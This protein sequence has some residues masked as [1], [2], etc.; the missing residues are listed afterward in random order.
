[1][2]KIAAKK[3][4]KANDKYVGVFPFQFDEGADEEAGDAAI[5]TSI[6]LIPIGQWEHDLYGPIIIT[7]NDILEFKANFDAKIRKGVPITAGHE[8]A[9]ELPAV[10]WI[11][12]VEARG[13]GLWGQVEWNE[14]G[15]DALEDKQFKF[16]SPEFYPIYEDAQTHTLYKN[17]LTGGALTKAPYFKELEAIVF[18]EKKLKNKFNHQTMTIA[19]LLA[20]KM[21]DLSTEEKAF[22]KEHAS[23]L[24][25]EQ[26][27]AYTSVIE[28]PTGTEETAEEKTA[29]EAK[30]KEV[31]EKKAADDKAAED[32]KAKGDA[33][34]AAGL[35]RDGSVKIDAS[36]KVHISAGE[37]AL[38][39]K[40]ADEG[41]QAFA[42]LKLQKLTA[43]VSALIFS[44]TNKAGKFL[45]KSKDTLHA[46][47][48]TLSDA[49]KASFNLLLAELPKTQIFSEIGTGAA[50]VEGT[51]QAE[52]EA[53][54]TLKMDGNKALKYSEALKLVF[55]E[56][57]G[58]T[59]RYHEEV[60]KPAIKA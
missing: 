15:E 47:M 30:E 38:L 7:A 50:A 22:I 51:A 31:A 24:T 26:K 28:E 41:K 12:K 8:G 57:K 32:E 1:M 43:A 53:K 25:D 35:N 11:T 14:M 33:N 23:E 42:E 18:S 9:L 19:E 21:E 45:P 58:L 4:S 6:H 20:K 27:A 17:V 13:D 37:L 2:T 55:E 40:A 10:G 34:E 54:V 16:F 46:F 60:S 56:N 5:P 29:R 59:E 39:K 3:Q 36:E 52:V 49:Q 44:E 48:E